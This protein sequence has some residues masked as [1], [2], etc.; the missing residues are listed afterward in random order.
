MRYGL[1][2]PI[3]CFQDRHLLEIAGRAEELGYTDIWSAESFGNDAFA[4]L[5]AIAAVTEKVRLGTA[6]VP[7]FTRPPALTAMSAATLQNLSNGRFILGLG[8]STPT[9]VQQWMGVPYEKPVTRLR[10]TIAALRTALK[11]DKVNV[12]GETVTINGFRLDVPA[13]YPPPPIYVAAQ[14]PL[15][16]AKAGEL[17]DGVIVNFVTTENLGAMLE[18]VNAGARKAG[19]DGGQ[20]D[21][22]CRII[23]L[24]DEN[25]EQ[26]RI[27]MRRSLTSYVTVPQ[28]NK[29]FQEFGFEREASAAIEKWNAGDRKGAV[30]SV[31]D[32]M[33][34]SIYVIGD[35]THCRK[36]LEEYGRAGVTTAAL[37]FASL[38]PTPEERRQRISLTIEKLAPK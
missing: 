35:A 26:A 18:H 38:A 1:T 11:R 16:L 36:R 31:S 15:M 27:L 24:C 28:Y 32:E 13:S 10:E 33:V 19:K 4:P 20:L 21:V 6:I 34:E 7:V 30:Q 25:E 2:L 37:L 23:V 22:V 14:G 3:E 9:I 17:G 5:A 29:F 8:I 12:A